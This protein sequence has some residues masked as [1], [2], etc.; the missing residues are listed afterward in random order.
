MHPGL[1][2]RRGATRLDGDRTGLDLRM[3]G[4]GRLHLAGLDARPPDLQLIVAAPYV[5]QDPGVLQTPGAQ[6]LARSP[7]S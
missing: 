3:A 6:N 4:E 2:G 1:R 7:V 5:L